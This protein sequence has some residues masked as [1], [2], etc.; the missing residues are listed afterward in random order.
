MVHVTRAATSTEW[1]GRL[2]GAGI[3]ANTF[4]YNMLL[5][6]CVID[7]DRAY[8]VWSEMARNEVPPDEFT[9]RLLV[10]AFSGN[11]TLASEIMQEAIELRSRLLGRDAQVRCLLTDC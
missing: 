9:L 1:S 7:K 10:R 11:A 2:A 8:Q 3:E 6:A 5:G 4:M